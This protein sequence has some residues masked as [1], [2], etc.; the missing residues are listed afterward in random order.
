MVKAN[1]NYKVLSKV[2][3]LVFALGHGQALI[4]RGFSINSN[5]LSENMK[6]KS[7][8]SR[9]TIKDFMMSIKLK[10]H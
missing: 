8:F 7:L 4:E 9:R 3:I 5:K 2:L 6:E 1:V 10:A